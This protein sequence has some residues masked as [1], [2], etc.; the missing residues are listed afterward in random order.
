[1]ELIL[2]HLTIKN[3]QQILYLNYFKNRIRIIN[4]L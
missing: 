1:M 3:Y 4:Y 2:H